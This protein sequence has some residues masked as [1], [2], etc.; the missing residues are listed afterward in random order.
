MQP[1]HEGPMVGLQSHPA[2]RLVAQ[3]EERLLDKQEV[4]GSIPTETTS[5]DS[6]S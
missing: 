1:P 3:V 6:G 4:V 2:D 5:A